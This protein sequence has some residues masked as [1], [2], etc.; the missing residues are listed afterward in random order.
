VVNRNNAPTVASLSKR[1]SNITGR[2]ENDTSLAK[3]ANEFRELTSVEE[4]ARATRVV[5]RLI[6]DPDL[7]KRPGE[8]PCRAQK[9]NGWIDA[10]SHKLRRERRCE[11]LGASEPPIPKNKC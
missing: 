4:D 6:T 1:P 8:R 10:Y 11:A 2:I 9:Y 5:N 3:G 7:V